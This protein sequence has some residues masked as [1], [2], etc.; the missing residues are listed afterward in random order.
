[1]GNS[2]GAR[3]PAALV[4]G[5]S[6][7]RRDGGHGRR[8]AARRRTTARSRAVQGRRGGR[9][10]RG[11]ATKESAGSRCWSIV[12]WR[13]PGAAGGGGAGLPSKEAVR[14]AGQQRRGRG[15]RRQAAALSLRSVCAQGRL[16]AAKEVDKGCERRKRRSAVPASGGAAAAR[17][18]SGEARPPEVP[19][20]CAGQRKRGRGRGRW[21]GSAAAGSTRGQRQPAA[22]PWPAGAAVG[23]SSSD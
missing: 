16:A 14:S 11:R 1:M 9:Q 23:G 8:P 5:V 7:Q 15:R 19:V 4:H 3:Q 10:W 17:G 6:L 12:A 20:R 2:T 13:R 18:D 21:R 22:A